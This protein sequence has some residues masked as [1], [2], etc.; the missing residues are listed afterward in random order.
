M[1]SF[2]SVV[3]MYSVLARIHIDLQNNTATQNIHF[4]GLLSNCVPAVHLLRSY[5]ADLW[6]DNLNLFEAF[7]SL[8]L[9]AGAGAKMEL[10]IF[11]GGTRCIACPRFRSE[12][13][14]YCFP[15][16]LAD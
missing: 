7:L 5:T 14:P 2:S 6:P 9:S 16:A 12:L 13:K 10:S 1:A 11:Y 4:L 3:N 15:L 8:S